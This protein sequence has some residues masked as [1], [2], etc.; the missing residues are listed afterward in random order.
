MLMLEVEQ[1]ERA[2]PL[3]QKKKQKLEGTRRNKHNF[4]FEGEVKGLGWLAEPVPTKEIV[5]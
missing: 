3:T 4:H 5:H 1:K 2:L